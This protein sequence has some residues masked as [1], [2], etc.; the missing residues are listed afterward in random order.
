MLIELTQKAVSLSGICKYKITTEYIFLKIFCVRGRGTKGTE[1]GDVQEERQEERQGKGAGRG[2][3]GEDKRK[4]RKKDRM[5][6]HGEGR[7]KEGAG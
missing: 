7:R 1:V 5:G 4:R 6:K 3:G 2:V